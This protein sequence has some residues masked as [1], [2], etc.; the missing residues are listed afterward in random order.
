MEV[1]GKAGTLIWR[2]DYVITPALHRAKGIERMAA[3]SILLLEIR[4]S[5]GDFQEY[6]QKNE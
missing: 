2:L 3:E 5:V 6:C 4:K 1:D